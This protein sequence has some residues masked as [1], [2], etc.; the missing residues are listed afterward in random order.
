M[1]LRKQTTVR[2]LKTSTIRELRTVVVL[3]IQLISLFRK[4]FNENSVL[5]IGVMSDSDETDILLLI[6]P[7]F[8]STPTKKDSCR[9]SQFLNIK[10]QPLN[11]E[12]IDKFNMHPLQNVPFESKNANKSNRDEAYKMIGINSKKCTLDDCDAINC[13]KNCYE[14]DIRSAIDDDSYTESITSKKSTYTLAKLEEESLRRK[15]C[16]RTIH[17]LEQQIQQFQDKYSDVIKMDQTKN[18]AMSRLHSTN[19]S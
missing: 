12:Y 15:Q 5:N 7:N 19:S 9:I 2:I 10:N 3:S 6:P 13:N 16:E 8:F 1:S 17:S 18:E 4:F 14:N 11:L